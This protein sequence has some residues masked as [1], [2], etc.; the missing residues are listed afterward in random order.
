MSTKN[1]TPQPWTILKSEMV[2]DE[3][4]YKLRRDEVELPNGVVL[5]DYYVSVRP[6]VVLI[7]PL[8]EDNHVIFV[9]QYKHAAGDVFI[10]LPGGVVDEDEAAPLAAAKRELLEETGYISDD[11]EPLLEVIDNPTKDTNRIYYYLARNAR[12]V[13]EQDLDISENI[14]VLKVPL[15]E[16]ES[17]V[18][19]GKV[20]VSGSIALSL[21][22]L[23]KL[24]V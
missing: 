4:W 16:V 8:T 5:D 7:F 2:V 10:E 22:V 15:Q 14:E 18:M 19:S 6:N 21:L 1:D 11:M 24:G 13:A 17:M 12:K 3:Q 20:N 23:R 9:R